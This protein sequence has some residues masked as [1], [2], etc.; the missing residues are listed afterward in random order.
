MRW[1]GREEE[2]DIPQICAAW[3]V[4]HWRAHKMVRVVGKTRIS[5]N[6]RSI[7]ECRQVLG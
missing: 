7:G 3:R 5:S 4:V 1:P 2:C 6:I